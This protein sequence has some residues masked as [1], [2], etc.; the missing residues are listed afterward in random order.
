LCCAVQ[1]APVAL[2]GPHDTSEPAVPVPQEPTA[3]GAPAGS[4]LDL[5]SA[6]DLGG[7]SGDEAA[8]PGDADGVLLG[9]LR[10]MPRHEGTAKPHV[11]GAVK[12]PQPAAG[13]AERSPQPGGDGS[14]DFMAGGL[15]D[16]LAS[17]D[18]QAGFGSGVREWYREIDP[19][20]GAEAPPGG[21]IEGAGMA[22]GSRD[23]PVR[24]RLIPQ[25][26]IDFLR[27]NRVWIFVGCLSCALLVLGFDVMRRNARGGPQRRATADRRLPMERRTSPADAAAAERRAASRRRAGPDRRSSTHPAAR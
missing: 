6:V 3:W 1:A 18:Q 16:A 22:E 19:G 9:L 12:S 24:E 25:P 10:D 26:V 27:E 15:F 8:L 11:D 13:P 4:R 14:G 7:R 21:R 23:K 5:P 17:G 20:A 2:D